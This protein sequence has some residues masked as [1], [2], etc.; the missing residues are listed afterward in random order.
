M[1]DIKNSTKRTLVALAIFLGLAAAVSLLGSLFTMS[2]QDGWYESLEQPSWDPPDWVF[3]PIWSV[4]YIA[5]GVA[6]WL[7]WRQRG[8]DGAK[9]PLTLWGIQLGL[10]LL[11]TAIFFGMEMPGL[12][13]IEIVVLIV[14]IIATVVTFWPI[15]K[16]GALLLLP[17]LGWVTFAAFLN[18]EIWRLN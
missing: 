14:A 18:F 11:W 15:S 13:V 2:G 17:Y 3:G 10:N 5:I 6:A 7:V 12:A 4:L 8:W 9:T 16:L 1:S